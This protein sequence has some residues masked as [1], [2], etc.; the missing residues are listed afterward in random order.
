VYTVRILTLDD[1]FEIVAWRYDPPYQLYNMTSVNASKDEMARMADF[2]LDPTTGHFAVEEN[3]QLLAFCCFGEEAQVPGYDYT[4]IEALDVGAGM[5]PMYTGQGRGR[6]LMA[7]IL[8]FGQK[9]YDPPC[10]RTTVATFNLR[11]QQMC[12]NAGFIPMATFTSAT[13]DPR[14]FVVMIKEG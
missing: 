7:A 8:A 6:A 13:Q 11:S 1:A 5:H 9:T 12:R 2:L 14:E 10:W 4:Q 3:G